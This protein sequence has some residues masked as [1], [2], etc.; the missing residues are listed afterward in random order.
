MSLI[1]HDCLGVAPSG[2]NCVVHVVTTRSYCLYCPSG[3][4][5]KESRDKKFDVGF[6]CECNHNCVGVAP[7]CW[8]GQHAKMEIFAPNN[9]S[10]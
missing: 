1:C 8:L 9:A 10:L 4:N 3:D 2:T 5:F 7:A 6:V